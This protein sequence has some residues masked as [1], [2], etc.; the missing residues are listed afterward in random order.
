MSVGDRYTPRAAAALLSEALGHLDV[1][2]PPAAREPIRQMFRAEI[3][4]C[5]LSRS[6][7]GQPVTYVLQLAEALV[8]PPV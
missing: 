8:A 4:R 3:E 1:V 7:L 2:E 6:L 5:T